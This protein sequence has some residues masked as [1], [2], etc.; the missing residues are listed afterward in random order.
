MA[1]RD[2]S[3]GLGNHGTG[4]VL[5]ICGRVLRTGTSPAGRVDKP[6]DNAHALPTALPTLSR[7]SPTSSTGRPTTTN[8]KTKKP[9][10]SI[11]CQQHP[12]AA[13]ASTDRSIPYLRPAQSTPN[14]A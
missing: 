13:V 8:F 12:F 11:C 9:D 3:V 7:L 10:S 5:W 14:T 1:D 4:A 6:V 2:E